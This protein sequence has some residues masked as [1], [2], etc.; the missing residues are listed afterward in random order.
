MF[1]YSVHV[2]NMQFQV[3]F[4]FYT[5]KSMVQFPGSRPK[6]NIFSLHTSEKK[7][8]RPL[9]TNIQKLWNEND[10]MRHFSVHD[11]GDWV[12]CV[13]FENISLAW[14]EPFRFAWCCSS[15][16][17]A[18][19]LLLFGGVNLMFISLRNKTQIRF[20]YFLHTVFVRHLWEVHSLSRWNQIGT[21]YAVQLWYIRGLER[22]LEITEFLNCSFWHLWFSISLLTT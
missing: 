6:K 8:R 10:V 19:S 18:R 5:I 11:P 22:V 1:F 16:V 7:F 9:E 13:V 12:F 4:F 21:V 14:Q 2:W 20:S 3:H 17:I 15:R